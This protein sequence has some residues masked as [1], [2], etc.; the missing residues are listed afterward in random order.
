M[1]FSSPHL[2]AVLDG[3]DRHPSEIA[4][5]TGR[6][7]PEEETPESESVNNNMGAAITFNPSVGALEL[8]EEGAVIICEKVRKDT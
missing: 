5:S 1:K 7:V 8:A 3:D 4:T 6:F 2:R